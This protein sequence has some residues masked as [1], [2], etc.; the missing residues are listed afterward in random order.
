MDLKAWT[1]KITDVLMP[2][3]SV[4]VEDEDRLGEETVVSM[5]RQASRAEAVDEEELKVANGGTV[6][7]SSSYR[8]TASQKAARR[9]QLTVHS[10]PQLKVRVYVPTNFDEVTGI[11]DD[12][13]ARMAVIVNYE[14]VEAEEQRRICDFVNGAC[15]VSDGGAK[16]ISDYIV[17]YVP[18]GIDVSEAM[19][20]AV[21]K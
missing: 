19:S 3:E 12:L 14:K 11:A 18:E 10:A 13:K 6:R 2:L 15:Y 4:D 1:K 17:L 21:L 9:P 16:R 5:P 20:V 7:V 8:G